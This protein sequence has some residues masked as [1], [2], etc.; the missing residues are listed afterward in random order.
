[1]CFTTLPKCSCQ[2]RIYSGLIASIQKPSNRL[3]VAEEEDAQQPETCDPD[4]DVSDDDLLNPTEGQHTAAASESGATKTT[5]K[6]DETKKK[7]EAKNWTRYQEL[8]RQKDDRMDFFVEKTEE[9]TRIYFSS[10]YHDKGLLWLVFYHLKAY[11]SNIYFKQESRQRPQWTPSS[12]ILPQLY[13][14]QWLVY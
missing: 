11:G 5:F 7:L 8:L 2:F 6:D 14:S 4:E 1:M 10:Y 12:T 3:Q 9:A 13:C